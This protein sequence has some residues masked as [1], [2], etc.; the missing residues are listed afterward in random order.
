M[1]LNISKVRNKFVEVRFSRL[2][3]GIQAFLIQKKQ[4]KEKIAIISVR[5]GSIDQE[6]RNNTAGIC[7]TPAGVAHFLEHQ[8]FKKQNEDIL[9]TFGKFGAS[10]NAFTGWCST[11]YFFSCTENFIPSLDLLLKLV[12]S[13]YFCSEYVEKEKLIIEQEIKMY[14]DM[15]DYRLLKNFLMTLYK[16]HPIRIDIAG[17]T[18]SIRKIKTETL[19]QCYDIFYHPSN[20][21]FICAGNLDAEEIFNYINSVIGKK[22][23]KPK[24][25]VRNI[26]EE[27]VVLDDK[28]KIEH[29]MF[30]SKPQVIVGFKD[31]YIPKNKDEYLLQELAT[32]LVLEIIFGKISPFY[33][34]AYQSDLI[35]SDFSYSYTSER[36]FGFSSIGGRT[37]DPENLIAKI[38][39]AIGKTKK[40]G[41]KSRDVDIL[42]RAALGKFIRIFESPRT[43]AF[44]FL[45]SLHKEI[46]I[47]DTIKMIGRLNKNLLTS[48]L[49]YHFR[50][51]NCAISIVKPK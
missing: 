44:S 41:I 46:D 11:S 25:I 40:D 2:D 28:N 38:Q 33:S 15:P 18:D 43:L 23:G 27:K 29:K 6:F 20:M 8:L 36:T 51:D 4:M 35:D 17:D 48:R 42:K 10:A 34:W 19:K 13:P 14:D 24:K 47:L 5:Y 3:S 16:K 26:P 9:S 32:D 21:F 7:T 49:H 31:Y 45:D 22:E 37:P 50:E 30:V 1:S 12:F 39:K